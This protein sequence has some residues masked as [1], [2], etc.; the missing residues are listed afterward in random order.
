MD[1]RAAG[2]VLVMLGFAGYGPVPEEDRLRAR[3][4]SERAQ[5]FET[6]CFALR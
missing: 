6:S 1:G 2:V 3:C 5:I 4:G